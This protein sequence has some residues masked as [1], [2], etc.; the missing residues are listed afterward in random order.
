MQL[1]GTVE[2]FDFAHLL[3]MLATV[4]KSGRLRLESDG[5]Q[6]LVLLRD[7]KIICTVSTSVRESLGSVLL[8][9]GWLTSSQL[10][11]G[12]AMQQAA[13]EDRR[14]GAILVE[15][16]YVGQDQLEAAVAEQA[17]QVISEFLRWPSSSFE[18][19]E[20]LFPDRGEVEVP[21]DRLPLDPGLPADQILLGIP[22]PNGQKQVVP[23]PSVEVP[24][25]PDLVRDFPAPLVTGEMAQKILDRAKGVVARGALFQVGPSEFI[26]LSQFGMQGYDDESP[27]F[28]RNVR[29][30]LRRDSILR[31]VGAIRSHHRGELE[32]TAGNRHLLEELGGGWPTEVFVGPLFAGGRV[33]L[34]FYGDNL[35]EREP[36]GDT[37]ELAAQLLRS[38]SMLEH[39]LLSRTA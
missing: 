32:S 27:D 4:G 35:P 2:G 22:S 38:G 9:R 8:S 31:K 18:F 19:E 5:S 15:A 29:V 37:S 17:G 3:Q 25:L 14:L 12:L 26:G 33:M 10:E 6:G 24:S 39:C 1:N 34:V 23:P 36:L 20:V 13:G 7:G 11:I 16:G 28:I 21:T 30:S